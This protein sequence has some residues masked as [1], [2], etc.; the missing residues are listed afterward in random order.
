MIRMIGGLL[1]AFALSFMTYADDLGWPDGHPCT[2]DKIPLTTEKSVVL[3]IQCLYDGRV[4]KVEKVNTDGNKWF[5]QLRVLLPG[6][7]IKTIDVHPETGM[8]L[9]PK[10]LEA[11][12]ET[13]NR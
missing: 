7:R 2:G 5:Y 12:N 3:A 11:I 8:P 10:E 6:G 4:A 13:L 9:D 1:F